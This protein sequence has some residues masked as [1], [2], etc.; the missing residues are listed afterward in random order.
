M[1][2]GRKHKTQ[3]Q[4]TAHYSQESEDPEYQ[5]FP[6]SAPYPSSHRAMPMGGDDACIHDR[7][8]YKRGVPSSGNPNPL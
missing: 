6:V 4:R 2:A 5:H 7:W 1:D 8:H 3:S